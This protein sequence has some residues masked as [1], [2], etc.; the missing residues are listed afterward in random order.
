MDQSY[1]GNVPR[2][3]SATAS[4]RHPTQSTLPWR[5]LV[6]ACRVDQPCGHETPEKPVIDT[7]SSCPVAASVTKLVEQRKG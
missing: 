2:R 6:A 7:Q 1:Y 3:A 5:E 4:G